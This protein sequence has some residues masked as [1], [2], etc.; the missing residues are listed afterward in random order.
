M[1]V[2]AEASVKR[3]KCLVGEGR[4]VAPFQLYYEVCG[5]GPEKVLFIMGLNASG[6]SWKYQRDYF[7]TL[8]EYSTCI[9]DNRGCGRSDSP[10]SYYTTTGMAQDVLELLKHLGWTESVNVVGVSLG[11]MIAEELALAAPEKLV[12]SLCLTSTN[13]GRTI[14]PMPALF[15]L[16]RSLFP[17]N[18]EE[19]LQRNIMMLYPEA[20]LKQAGPLDTNFPTNQAWVIED[21]KERICT[22]PLQPSQGIRGQLSAGARHYVSADR[23]HQIRNKGFPILVVTGDM[24]CMI[25]P[26]HSYYLAGELNARLEIFEGCGHVLGVQVK[27]RYNEL[28]QEHFQSVSQR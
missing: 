11:G 18:V 17:S 14:P 1:A 26:S 19:Q 2:M 24:D 25:Y 21:M 12:K 22:I 13:A 4:E 7:K 6:E 5:T 15:K 8:P 28:L 9:F 3:G 27:D 20:W 10:N 23:L 16:V